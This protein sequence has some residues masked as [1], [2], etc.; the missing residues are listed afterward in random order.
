MAQYQQ[1][2]AFSGKMWPKD[3]VL[4]WLIDAQVEKGENN[5]LPTS[6]QVEAW[7][8]D[9]EAAMK[10]RNEEDSDD[11]EDDDSNSGSEDEEPADAK[12]DSDESDDL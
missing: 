10:D 7:Y 4:Q 6:E 3:F 11:S 9:E 5:G 8:E 2:L 12:E 1:I